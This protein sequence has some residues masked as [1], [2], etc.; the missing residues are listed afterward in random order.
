[1]RQSSFRHR[2][3]A[4][5]PIIVLICLCPVLSFH[6]AAGADSPKPKADETSL[7][8]T[9]PVEYSSDPASR[10]LDV[11]LTAK[12][13]EKPIL[14]LTDTASRAVKVHVPAYCGDLVGPTLR[15]H[16]GDR[17]RIKVQNSL[18][19]RLVPAD[20]PGPGD[21]DLPHGFAVTNLHTHGLHVSPRD[22]AD[23][24]YVEIQPGE[25]RQYEYQI[26]PSHQAG[27]FWYHAHRHGSVAYQLTS[28][29]AGTLIVEDD[30][31]KRL[32]AVRERVMV[33]QQMHGT[34][35]QTSGL[36]TPLPNQI[37]DKLKE[38]AADQTNAPVPAGQVAASRS[39]R[40][41]MAIRQNARRGKRV[42]DLPLNVS[43]PN[44]DPSAPDNEWLLLNGKCCPT[45]HVKAGERE[46][47]RFVHAGI[48]E[49][50]HLAVVDE[51]YR[52]QPMMQIAIDG[53][54]RKHGES[55]RDNL[56]YP[57]Y[58]WDVIFQAPAPSS[59]TA[60]SF[61]LI[62]DK[63]LANQTLS[64]FDKPQNLIARICVDANPGVTPEKLESLAA[65]D[66]SPFIAEEYKVDI[67]DADVGNRR[68][69]LTFDF[70]D[71]R[72][73][74]LYI[75]AQEFSPRIDRIVR[76]NTAEE[77]TIASGTDL[78][79]AAGHPFHIHVNP[80]QHLVYEKV[81]ALRINGT[82]TSTVT[83]ESTLMDLGFASTDSTAFT[84]CLSG[85]TAVTTDPIPA[86]TTLGALQ[87]A[88]QQFLDHYYD[89]GRYLVA[90]ESE[91][92]QRTTDSPKPA[93]QPVR[94]TIRDTKG[95]IEHLRVDCTDPQ[96]RL[97]FTIVR[98]IIDR[99][100]RDTLMAPS[101]RTE[102]VRM[103]FRDW[104]G[105][106]VLHC[107][108]VDHEDQGMMKNVLILGEGEAAPPDGAPAARNA[109]P[110][111]EETPATPVAAPDFT[112]TD[113][114]NKLRS[115]RDFLGKKVILVFYR[116]TGCVHCS[117]QMEAF[118]K[119]KDQIDRAGVTL[120]AVSSQ[121]AGDLQSMA[122]VRDDD[123]RPF[124]LL[125]DGEHQIFRQYG[126]YADQ[127]L[128]RVLVIDPRGN[129][130]WKSD[131]GPR[132]FM[133]VDLVLSKAAASTTADK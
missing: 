3:F 123:P 34:F 103:R 115:L 32:G 69:A 10:L 84:F 51:Q 111:E 104:T 129:L 101:G 54:T 76:L 86:T 116:G 52:P 37:Y 93:M 126:C 61:Y 99:I 87:K 100:W 114:T 60:Q 108:I 117:Q 15:I 24:I 121:D 21:F 46:R 88:F 119:I 105:E 19:P 110:G 113:E 63:A 2:L 62:D 112:L 65:V 71:A 30:L 92:G 31:N 41:E 124:I 98:R 40:A 59:G 49:V 8:F 56:L 36:W 9:N 94:M 38:L 83:S 75:N 6:A 131:A 47:W 74:H 72:P 89:K 132:P 107:H 29:M 27:T 23:N 25:R 28:G 53:I 82:S 122:A 14:N 18:D 67:S 45:L 11:T 90:L 96:G 64:G 48:D 77:W 26:L 97:S 57:G 66:L 125:A 55:K 79:N 68:W 1:M 91:T 50:I 127:P 130:T 7:E 106:T 5:R 44:P 42:L 81:L 22:H 16:K 95:A 118:A 133:N 120:I 33:L 80:F 17:L 35:C 128:H 109:T 43:P 12:V 4:I 13:I 39:R 58:R 102:S 70:P 73:P 78:K 85:G 20:P